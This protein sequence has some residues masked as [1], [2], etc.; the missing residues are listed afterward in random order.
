MKQLHS[1]T[2]IVALTALSLTTAAHAAVVFT[3][4][5]SSG[6]TLISGTGPITFDGTITGNWHGGGV[7]TLAGEQLTVTDNRTLGGFIW[8]DSSSWDDGT[9]TV[10]F[11][12]KTGGSASYFEVYYANGVDTVGNNVSFDPQTNLGTLKPVQNG[13]AI[14]GTLGAK[15][16]LS[17]VADDQEFTFDLNGEE[18]IAL[19]FYVVNSALT[20]DNITVTTVPEPGTYALLGGLLALSYV[21]VRRRR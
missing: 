9:V 10:E 3:E 18:N 11:D 13:T 15:N 17:T 19:A 14:L 12:V 7:S 4:D 16:V 5:F 1:I 6:T 21:M 8:L 20:V 2:G